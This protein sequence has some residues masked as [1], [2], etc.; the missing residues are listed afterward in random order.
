[1]RLM[2]SVLFS[3]FTFFVLA[4][5]DHEYYFNGKR[6]SVFFADFQ[7]H[8]YTK[9]GFPINLDGAFDV[10]NADK[11]QTF[12]INT[13]DTVTRNKAMLW[14]VKY[15]QN[16]ITD[17]REKVII[18]KF[19]VHIKPAPRKV[20]LWGKVAAGEKLVISD[21]D[22]NLIL[23][24]PEL[25]PQFNLLEVHLK[26]NQENLRVR[27]SKLSDAQKQ[28]IIAL[29]EDTRIDVEMHYNDGRL[30]DRVVAGY[31]LR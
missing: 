14:I 11:F 25:K 13:L 9:Q 22:F 28:I 15:E 31:F 7:N 23:D 2:C 20:L 4:Q 19:E 16:P 24:H 8:F 29:P 26:F 1:M 17:E 27:G 3:L 5:T 6:D 10:Q 21:L 18:D 12:T 30:R